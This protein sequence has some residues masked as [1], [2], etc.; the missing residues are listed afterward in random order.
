MGFRSASIK[1]LETSTDSLIF[2]DD[3]NLGNKN[4]SRLFSRSPKNVGIIGRVI[5]NGTMYRSEYYV[6]AMNH[7][8]TLLNDPSIVK[9]LYLKD[10]KPCSVLCFPLYC[11]AF[12]HPI[13]AIQFVDKLS[14]KLIT[15][16]DITRAKALSALLGSMLTNICFVSERFRNFFDINEAI[17]PVKDISDTLYN[18]FSEGSSFE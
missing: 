14:K 7:D 6:E 2:I 8:S 16:E 13:G 10:N 12:S 17:T 5:E 11:E 15:E 1:L 4:N 3:E 18:I 9:K